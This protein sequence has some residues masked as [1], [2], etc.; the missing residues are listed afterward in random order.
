MDREGRRVWWQR[1]LVGVGRGVRVGGKASG[2]PSLQAPEKRADIF[3]FW[4]G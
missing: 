4:G 3:F 1:G 2:C